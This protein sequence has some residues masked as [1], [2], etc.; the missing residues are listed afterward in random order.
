MTENGTSLETLLD[1]TSP[2]RRFS[3][4]L[5]GEP[6]GADLKQY[7]EDLEAEVCRAA[8]RSE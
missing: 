4:V 3:L 2:A 1:Q 7:A 5:D 6:A 8:E